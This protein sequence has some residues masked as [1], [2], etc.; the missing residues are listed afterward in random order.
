MRRASSALSARRSGAASADGCSTRAP[1]RLLGELA[2]QRL[3]G[4]AAARLVDGGVDRDRCSQVAKRGSLVEAGQEA[5]GA[6]EGLLHR[7]FR[8][9]PLA[10]HPV[11]EAID[12]P[13]VRRNQTL[14]SV[15]FAGQHPPHDLELP[16]VHG[17]LDGAWA[18]PVRCDR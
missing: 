12:R 7:V 14:E 16:G 9:R 4:A 3:L 17:S 13:A 1:G 11:G 18:G 2:A 8:R 10:D 5:V 6:Q 15:G